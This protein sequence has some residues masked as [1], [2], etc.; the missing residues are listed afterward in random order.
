MAPTAGQWSEKWC[1]KNFQFP[2]F[3]LHLSDISFK[4]RKR[5]EMA[6]FLFVSPIPW[7][8]KNKHWQLAGRPPLLFNIFDNDST[9][10]S[11]ALDRRLHHAETLIIDGKSYRMK[12]QIETS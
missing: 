4:M 8:L 5:L 6:D 10:T 7:G 1:Q 9:L 2:P 11:T 3:R 12:D